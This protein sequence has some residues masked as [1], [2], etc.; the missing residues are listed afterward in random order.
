MTVFFWASHNTD[1]ESNTGLLQQELES[2]ASGRLVILAEQNLKVLAETR[3]VIV[4][5]GLGVSESLQH[6][7]GLGNAT[8]QGE[9][10][11]TIE[12]QTKE[13]LR[14]RTIGLDTRR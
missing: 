8:E 6:R 13:L 12:K 7:V 1:L 4:T 14:T 5:H 11:Q 10:K 2:L 9:E 3:R